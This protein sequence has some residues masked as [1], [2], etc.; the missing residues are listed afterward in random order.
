MAPST[1]WGL[2]MYMIPPT[3]DPN[4]PSQGERKI[5]RMLAED[6]AHPDWIVLH[7]QDVARHRSQMEGEIDFLIIAP[8]LGVL[9][10]EVKGSRGIFRD[11]GVWRDHPGAE[12]V[13]KSPFNQASEAMHSVQKRVAKRDKNL[14]DVLFWSAACFPNRDFS[15][16]S[17]EWES[18]QVIDKSRLQQ[19][20]IGECVESVLAQARQRA[21][22][23]DLNW[24]RFCKLRQEPTIRQ[25][26]AIVDILRPD[27]ELPEQPK[28][29]SKRIDED[30][31]RFTEEQF[32]ALDLMQLYS[33]VVFDG[34][35][36]TGKTVLAIEHSRRSQAA[37]KNVLFLCFNRALCTWLQDQ[38]SELLGDGRP[39]VVTVRTVH[40]YMEELIGPTVVRTLRDEVGYGAEAP[41]DVV[42]TYWNRALP[43]AAETK[44]LKNMDALAGA[45]ESAP[46]DPTLAPR[47]G[48]YDD[49]VVDEAQDVVRDSFLGVLDLCVR[50]GLAKGTWQMFGDF[51][52]QTIFDDTV[53]LKSFC[54]AHKCHPTPLSKN[55]RNTPSVAGLACRLGSVDPGYR[56]VLRDDDDTLPVVEYYAD[57]EQQR[58]RLTAVLD[59]LTEAGY[60]GAQILVLSTH[61]DDKSCAASLTEQPWKDRLQLLVEGHG[62]DGPVHL[63]TGQT[64]YCSMRRAKGLEAG[65]VVLTDVDDLSK[66]MAR[67]I[68]YVGASRAVD[69]LVILAHESVRD[70]LQQSFV[71]K[72]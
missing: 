42:Q 9:V 36:G 55:C 71:T 59:S 56:A 16:Q 7:S 3:I 11:K 15:T 20:P 64:H 31:R 4:T 12:G 19:R 21:E 46:F 1:D 13:M 65:A 28:D 27:Y 6:D 66:Q 10:L 8:G 72:T 35:A 23:L 45:E 33:Q 25:R 63:D 39:P 52:W 32:Y 62:A 41:R 34:P 43:D 14:S 57:E 47:L 70:Q 58:E 51:E 44:L 69:R 60:S 2:E 61:A 49:L 37:E 50:G 48:I 26:D 5:F 17:E 30:I 22:E 67:R 38:T 40:Q 29:R 68:V 24:F 54:H 18:W 53:S